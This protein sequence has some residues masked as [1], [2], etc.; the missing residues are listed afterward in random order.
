MAKFRCKHTGNIFTY[1]VPHDINTMRE[2]DEYEEVEEEE[3]S[4]LTETLPKKRNIG[5]PPKQ[6][7]KL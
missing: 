6:K 7:E 4:E 1:T 3:Q 5:R 2:H